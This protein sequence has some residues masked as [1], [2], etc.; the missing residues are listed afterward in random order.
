MVV[1]RGGC[2]R[3]ARPGKAIRDRLHV[4]EFRRARSRRGSRAWP[5]ADD[6]WACAGGIGSVLRQEPAAFT[7]SHAV[8]VGAFAIL[9]PRQPPLGRKPCGRSSIRVTYRRRLSRYSCILLQFVT[10]FST[11]RWHNLA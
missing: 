6:R 5:H 1:S 2:W 8:A 9:S 10:H 7:R 11:R 4:L 3:A